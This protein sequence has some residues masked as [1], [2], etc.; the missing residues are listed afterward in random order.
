MDKNI[1]E[2][3]QAKYSQIKVVEVDGSYLI[4]DKPE[5][6]TIM[7]KVM[8][9]LMFYH[10]GSIVLPLQENAKKKGDEYMQMSQLKRWIIGM[11]VNC[12][13][14]TVGQLVAYVACSYKNVS[15][16][17][18][19]MEEEQLIERFIKP[20]MRRYVFVKATE[21]AKSIHRAFIVAVCQEEQ[22]LFDK[23]FSDEDQIRLLYY[24]AKIGEIYLNSDLADINKK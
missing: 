20:K 10:K 21:K 6:H 17:L 19:E 15:R 23:T 18:E 22:L 5:Y 24:Y 1:I 13:D 2:E 8:D 3:I 7:D 11:L 14:C 9:H 4:K 16:V 12:G